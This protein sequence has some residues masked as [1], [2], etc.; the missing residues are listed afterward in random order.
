MNPIVSI[1]VL[2]I[3]SVAV[4]A[5]TVRVLVKQK[6]IKA[7]GFEA[8]GVIYELSQSTNPNDNIIFPVIRFLTDKNIWITKKSNLGTAPGLYKKGQKVKIIY[9]KDD[10]E[11]FFIN[12]PSKYLIP[13]VAILIS[14][15]MLG[16]GVFLLLHTNLG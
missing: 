10:P 8:T 9:Q 2:I 11:N 14:V 12:N 13:L 16:Y 7:N 5:I 15:A 6:K 1:T 3:C 4:L